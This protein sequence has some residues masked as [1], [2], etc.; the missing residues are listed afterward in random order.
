MRP[1]TAIHTMMRYFDHQRT[2]RCHN[3]CQ[4]LAFTLIEL[5]VVIA[6]IGILVGISLPAVQMS[7][8]SGRRMSCSNHLRQIGIA[9]SAFESTYQKLPP[10]RDARQ[11]QNHSWSTLALPFLEQPAIFERYDFRTAMDS[12][13]NAVVGSTNLEVFRCPSAVDEWPG[14][15]DY[16]GNYGSTLTGLLP[17]FGRGRGWDAGT[18]LSIGIPP[19]PGV[20]FRQAPVAMADVSDGASHTFLVLENADRPAAE[21]GLWVSGHNCFAQDNGPINGKDD[22]EITSRHPGGA[23]GLL[24]DGSTQFL[25]EST[26]L[27]ILGSL[28]TRAGREVIASP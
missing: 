15:S 17:G 3:C 23:H 19:T 21:G 18:L 28:C 16:G 1:F 27:Q 6:V 2:S 7:R 5:F 4:R 14:K 9:L 26:D 13:G 12:P 11:S 10:G 25:T 20:Y 8:E 24:V 22:N